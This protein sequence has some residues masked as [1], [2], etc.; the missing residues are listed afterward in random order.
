MK[1][2]YCIYALAGGGAETQL[3]LLANRIHGSNNQLAIFFV[4]GDM[5]SDSTITFF[6]CSREDYPLGLIGQID[7][8]IGE[9]KPDIVHAWVPASINIATLIAGRKNRVPVITSIRNKRRIDGFQRLCSYLTTFLLSSGIISNN[10]IG[11][12]S[13]PYRLLFRFK[14]GVVIGNAVK[15]SNS[16][17]KLRPAVGGSCKLIYVGRLTKQKNVSLLIS[18]LKCLGRERPISLDIYGQGEDEQFL[19]ALV[20]ELGL[21][22]KVVFN[23]FS[24]EVYSEIV[25]ADFLV[26]PSLYEGMP[27]VV[28]EALALG[29][30]A[31]VSNIP[32]HS[33]LFKNQEVVFF[34]SGNVKS[35]EDRLRAILNQQIDIENMMVRSAAF[36]SQR[37]IDKVAHNYVNTY[38][39]VLKA[40]LAD[41]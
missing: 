30:P 40:Q 11:Q 13:W 41:G 32:A 2:L 37:T 21:Q 18:A 29:V 6:Q 26:L 1:I 34:E 22:G 5:P 10:P 3:K 25:K 33:M 15:V 14:R 9:F 28:V 20:I 24:S 7:N 35:L 16:F 23:G 38:D 39:S 12:S 4:K 17:A 31:L 8:A 27:N 36:V 19:R